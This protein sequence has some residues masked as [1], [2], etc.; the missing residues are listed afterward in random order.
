MAFLAMGLLLPAQTAP[1]SKPKSISQEGLT[2]ALRIGGLSTDELVAIVLK[3]GVAFQMT[4]QIESSL[5]AAG[6]ASALIDAVR[7]NYRPPEDAVPVPQTESP[8]AP[9]PKL[10]PLAE[11]EILTLLQVGTPSLRVAQMV[12]ERGISFIT[13]PAIAEELET[14]GADVHLLDAI[15]AAGEK[16]NDQSPNVPVTAAASTTPAQPSTPAI[17]SLKQVRKLY[18][19]KMGGNLDEYLRVEIGKQLS[20]RFQIVLNKDIADA[21]II[22][23]GEQ[24]KDVGSVLTGGYL[25]L[26]DTATG[27]VSMVNKQGIVLWSSSAGDRTL[28]L[29]PLTRGGTPEVASRLVQNLKKAV[30]SE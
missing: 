28:L 2:D 29:G 22:G 21:L 17:N 4:D 6:A 30:Q 13:T 24:T 16:N 11:S 23:T 25:G 9:A 14:S 5:R 26:H 10:P 20:W 15:N 3:R 1:S 7:K 12:R 18:V 27:A 8:V 19:D